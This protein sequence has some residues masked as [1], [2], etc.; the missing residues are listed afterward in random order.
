MAKEAH[1]TEAHITIDM[2]VISWYFVVKELENSAMTNLKNMAHYIDMMTK[3]KDYRE[4]LTI[5]FPFVDALVL[6]AFC[7]GYSI[8]K[9]EN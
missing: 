5:S 2:E 8:G 1:V 4:N 7:E 3:G 6:G 9:G